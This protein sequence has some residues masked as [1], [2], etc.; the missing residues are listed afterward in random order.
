ML[1]PDPETSCVRKVAYRTF[2]VAW[3][4]RRR[5]SEKF[6]DPGIEPYYCVHCRQWHLGHPSPERLE[7][8]KPLPPR[9]SQEMLD[10][11]QR[12]VRALE[13]F[14]KKYRTTPPKGWDWEGYEEEFIK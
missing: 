4:E 7:R 2:L 11:N 9:K 8:R 3:N 1:L 6:N 12:K 5:V 13:H 14:Q 10:E